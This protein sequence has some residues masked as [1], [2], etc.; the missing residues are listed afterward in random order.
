VADILY[1]RR[2]LGDRVGSAPDVVYAVVSK[3]GERQD[4]VPV[5]G[6]FPPGWR[7]TENPGQ[8][9][10]TRAAGVG[11]VPCEVPRSQFRHYQRIEEGEAV[12]LYADIVDSAAR[13]SLCNG[14]SGERP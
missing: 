8:I 6:A 4:P 7:P 9:L 1:Y 2:A 3:P 14:G 13:F 5:L 12:R 10:F 11:Y